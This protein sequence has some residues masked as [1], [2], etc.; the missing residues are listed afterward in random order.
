M[1]I[2]ATVD[3]NH[4]SVL[5]LGSE[6]L[7]ALLAMIDAARASLRLLYYIFADDGTGRR[8]ADAMIAA[9]ARG[10]RVRL[11]IDGFG[12]QTD[13]GSAFVMRLR[14]AG[15]EVC[16]F[17]PRLGRRY[18]LRNHQKMA[19]ADAEAAPRALIGGF[20]VAD[21][22][23]DDGPDGW[24]DLGVVIEG[25]AAAQLSGYFDALADWSGKPR[26]PMR[27]LRRALTKWSK[28]QGTVR[29]LHG[30]PMRRLS[31]WNKAIRADLRIARS[32]ALIAAYFAPTRG[33]T[34]LIDRAA[35]RGSARIVTAGRTDNPAT[36][37][38][39]RFVFPGLLRKGARVFEYRPQRLHSK[40]YVVDDK[41]WLGSANLDPRSLFLNLEVMLRVDDAAFADAMR[42]YVEGEIA[43]SR[44]RTLGEFS[45]VRAFP[46]RIRNAISWFLVAVLDPAVT[47][48]F[49]MGID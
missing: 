16:V 39:A 47:R 33:L 22:Y 29:W 14:D 1:A 31:P 48:R 27:Q 20:N 7:D 6:R 5:T 25:A 9:A 19:I 45:G 26:A 8:V 12:S 38:A 40:L 15:I 24:R 23:F 21:P 32:V 4:L 10:V 49:N 37:G 17:I 2:T 30:G 44:E 11:I 43:D 3:N 42:G 18:L 13:G 46:D 34:T 36:I 41:T 28:P 35:E